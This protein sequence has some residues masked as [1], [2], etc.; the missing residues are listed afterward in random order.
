M[1]SW[2]LGDFVWFIIP[3]HIQG[4][5][6]VLVTWLIEILAL[7]RIWPGCGEKI[8]VKTKYK[9]KEIYLKKT[10]SLRIKDELLQI[11]VNFNACNEHLKASPCQFSRGI[12]NVS[13][14]IVTRYYMKFFARR[15]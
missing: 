6:I 5:S 1:I 13:S 7:S 2:C 15:F 3:P 12:N 8:L 9:N 4:I 11:R 10:L 14:V